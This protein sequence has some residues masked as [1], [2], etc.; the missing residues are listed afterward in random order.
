[1][2]G[3]CEACG[4]EVQAVHDEYNMPVC[5]SCEGDVHLSIHVPDDE[6]E[7]DTDPSDFDEWLLNG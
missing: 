4:C 5:P 2:I 6:D 7:D 1:M 3:Y